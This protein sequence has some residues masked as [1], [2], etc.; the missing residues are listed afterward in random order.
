[1]LHIALFEP[2][3]P[4]NTGNIIRLC[5]NTGFQLHLIEPL[6]FSL[7]HSRLRRAGL[8]YREFARVQVHRDYPAFLE[9]IDPS[10]LFAMSTHGTRGYHQVE[11]RPGDCLLFGPETRG[12]PPTLR[13]SVPQ[14]HCLRIP[15]GPDSRSLNLSNAAALV[16][17]EAWR[18]LDFAGSVNSTTAVE[19]DATVIKAASGLGE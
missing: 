18:Q 3:I 16:A 1:M 17:Y 15:M 11:Y 4:P 9:H 13:E 10:R 19:S 8:D 14:G 6:G 5:A 2:E 12:L 7:D